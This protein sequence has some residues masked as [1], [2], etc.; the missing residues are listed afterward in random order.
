MIFCI[1]R[2]RAL[3]FK[4]NSIRVWDSKSEN[5]IILSKNPNYSN[6]SKL[7]FSPD[8]T[9]CGIIYSRDMQVAMDYPDIYFIDIF[10]LDLLI[11]I[12]E[13]KSH[14]KQEFSYLSFSRSNPKIFSVRVHTYNRKDEVSSFSDYF[15]IY[16]N[17]VNKKIYIKNITIQ[18]KNNL[19]TLI[20]E[21]TNLKTL[22]LNI[23]KIDKD[24]P[25]EIS[26]NANYFLYT[27]NRQIKILN[28]QT[29][30]FIKVIDLEG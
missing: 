1:T 12:S 27:F 10:D 30:S 29:F 4:N 21:K 24:S 11:K 17:K 15:D 19:I 7:Y 9:Y 25:L 23:K 3:Y 2:E 22:K 8:R 18:R 28:L 5:D 20:D 13:I 6:I 14:K 26:Q 16:G